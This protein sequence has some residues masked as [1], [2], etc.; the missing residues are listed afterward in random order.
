[1]EMAWAAFVGTKKELDSLK[2][3]RQKFDASEKNNQRMKTSLE[4]CQAELN[5]LAQ[6]VQH[7]KN[8]D[9]ELKKMMKDTKKK[10]AEDIAKLASMVQPSEKRRVSRLI[11]DEIPPSGVNSESFRRRLESYPRRIQS[12]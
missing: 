12:N 3:L 1:M 7:L 9:I 2:D 8:S 11:N 10:T 4:V 5:S 6:E